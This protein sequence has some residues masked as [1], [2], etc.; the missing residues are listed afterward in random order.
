MNTLVEHDASRRETMVCEGIG[1]EQRLALQ[2][3]KLA[4][5]PGAAYLPCA[6]TNG[7]FEPDPRPVKKSNKRIWGFAD[8]GRHARDL[9]EGRI[10]KRI[11]DVVFQQRLQ[12][13]CLVMLHGRGA[14]NHRDF[15]ILGDQRKRTNRKVR[16]K[17]QQRGI[18]FFA[19]G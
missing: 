18:V 12:P 11:K 8:R 6:K 13:F 10:W 9:I 14:R 17:Y 7:G 16:G 19:W 3:Q 4:G 2:Q 1:N 5:R 15:C